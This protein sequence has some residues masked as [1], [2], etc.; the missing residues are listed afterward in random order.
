M[1][2]GCLRSVRH[3]CNLSGVS[4]TL[5][6]GGHILRV[7]NKRPWHARHVPSSLS[8]PLSRSLFVRHRT[9]PWQRWL[10]RRHNSNFIAL[11]GCGPTRTRPRIYG[12]FF[13]LIFI[14]STREPARRLHKGDPAFL[15]S[16]PATFLRPCRDPCIQW[17]MQGW[18]ALGTRRIFQRLSSD[19]RDPRPGRWL[20]RV[21]APNFDDATEEHLFERRQ[22]GKRRRERAARRQSAGAPGVY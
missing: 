15:P 20:Y 6:T 10:E 2:R 4:H 13:L 9:K 12:Q 16:P 7:A 18:R 8:L 17:R 21:A 5:G 22:V 14:S 11:A 19:S 1:T 3:G